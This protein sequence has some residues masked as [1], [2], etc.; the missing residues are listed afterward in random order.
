MRI[1][2]PVIYRDVGTMEHRHQRR[3]DAEIHE[4]EMTAE[5]MPTPGMRRACSVR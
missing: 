3:F 1:V 2:W 4:G 5:T